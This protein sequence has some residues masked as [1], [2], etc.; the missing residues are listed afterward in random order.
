MLRTQ[1]SSI[2][3]CVN[4]LDISVW[5]SFIHSSSSYSLKEWSSFN[6]SNLPNYGYFHLCC[7]WWLACDTWRQYDCSLFLLPSIDPVRS[8]QLT[9]SCI[10]GWIVLFS[11]MSC[12]WTSHY[13]CF[14]YRLSSIVW[15]LHL[16]PKNSHQGNSFWP[17]DI[18]LLFISSLSGYN[19]RIKKAIDPKYF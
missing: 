1:I 6:S 14:I 12:V 3:Y 10:F 5:F 7:C 9:R 19:C 15:F 2:L 11:I 4:W 8:T 13:H 17:I 18:F 16:P